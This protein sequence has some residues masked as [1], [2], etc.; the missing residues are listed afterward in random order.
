M[1]QRSDQMNRGIRAR[2]DSRTDIDP[3]F[4]PSRAFGSATFLPSKKSLV[5]TVK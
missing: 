1:R 3:L 4:A 5:K 2:L